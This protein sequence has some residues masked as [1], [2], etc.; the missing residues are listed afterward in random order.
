MMKACSFFFDNTYIQ[1][2]FLHFLQNYIFIFFEARS[3][4]WKQI[5]V[6]TCF[7]SVECTLVVHYD[8][9]Q[10][11]LPCVA[12]VPQKLVL[13]CHTYIAE[14]LASFLFFFF[15]FILFFVYASQCQLGYGVSN[16][17]DFKVAN[18]FKRQSGFDPITFRS[19]EN[20]N[21]GQE[22]FL[23]V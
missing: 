15:V 16:F 4:D 12:Y 8:D 22:S 10:R 17:L 7:K 13:P 11:H 18:F 23:E 21:Y 2:F 3:T 5:Q 9:N 19:T 14:K 1:T 6:Q 20:S